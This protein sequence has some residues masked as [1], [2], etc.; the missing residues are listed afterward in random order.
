ME[1]EKHL[2]EDRSDEKSTPQ[3]DSRQAPSHGAGPDHWA[4][5]TEGRY[6]DYMDVGNEL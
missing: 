1:N 4:S 2:R 6:G 3:S 5:A